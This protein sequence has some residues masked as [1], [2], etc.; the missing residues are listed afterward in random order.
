MAAGDFLDL[1]DFVASTSVL[2][3]LAEL[4]SHATWWKTRLLRL[5]LVPYDRQQCPLLSVMGYAHTR[6]LPP[7]R[8]LPLLTSALLLQ[9]SAC[10]HSPPRVLSMDGAV[11]IRH[12]SWLCCEIR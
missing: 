12:I 6:C 3:G 8:S 11:A 9:L 7:I 5:V 4:L 2:T 10:L 1:A